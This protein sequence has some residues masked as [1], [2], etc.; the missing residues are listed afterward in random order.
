[1]SCAI[2]DCD[3]QYFN[4]KGP[5]KMQVLL[6]KMAYMEYFLHR[7]RIVRFAIVTLLVNIEIE[8]CCP[9]ALDSTCVST[10]KQ[11]KVCNIANKY[12]LMSFQGMIS[13]QEL[14]CAVIGKLKIVI[15]TFH[16][17]VQCVAG[18]V[19]TLC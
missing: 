11:Y 6:K 18:I 5:A 4:I 17:V 13:R 19:R 8:S 2:R 14:K 16:I 15:F 3:I 7:T 12:D 10:S 1:M 9:K